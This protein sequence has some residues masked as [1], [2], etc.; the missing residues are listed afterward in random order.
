MNCVT[1]AYVTLEHQWCC[2]TLSA[3]ENMLVLRLCVG[4]SI[5]GIA[6]GDLSVTLANKDCE[7]PFGILLA[8]LDK[9]RGTKRNFAFFIF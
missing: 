4:I 8:C 9:Q 2:V 5:L 3:D 6:T 1:D 7:V